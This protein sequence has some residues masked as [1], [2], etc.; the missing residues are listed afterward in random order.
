MK[1][2]EAADLGRH[3][4]AGLGERCGQIIRLQHVDG[5]SDEEVVHQR[6]AKYSTPDSLKIKRRGGYM[7]KLTQIAQQWKISNNM[8]IPAPMMLNGMRS[9]RFGWVLNKFNWKKK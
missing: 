1:K 5:V 4:L 2:W 8:Q 6:L 7:K 9:R 3:L